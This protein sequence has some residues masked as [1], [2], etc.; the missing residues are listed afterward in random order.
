LAWFQRVGAAEGK[1]KAA[2]GKQK[3]E[4]WLDCK[5]AATKDLLPQKS[6][7][8]AKKKQHKL[9]SMCSLRSFVAKILLELHDSTLLQSKEPSMRKSLTLFAIRGDYPV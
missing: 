4:L 2:M 5:P 6:A 1:Q 9:L 7:K 8:I 3:S